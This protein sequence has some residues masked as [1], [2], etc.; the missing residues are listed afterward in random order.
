VFLFLLFS[1]RAIAEKEIKVGTIDVQKVM[2]SWAKFKNYSSQMEQ[3]RIAYT[4][5]LDKA[6]SN[7][8]EA[9]RNDMEYKI[10]KILEHSNLILMEVLTNDMEKAAE[11]I[12]L[13]KGFS[14][15]FIKQRTVF[16]GTDITEDLVKLLK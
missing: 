7:L 8:N 12:A 10:S 6:S 14:V 15:V 1:S 13:E 5:L 11:K 2:D 9:E 16:G 4:I 3:E